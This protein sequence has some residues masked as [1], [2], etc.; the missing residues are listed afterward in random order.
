MKLINCEKCGGNDFFEQ[1]GYRICRYCRS[2]YAL[3]A[4]DIFPQGSRIS[5][6]EDIK[7]L[8]QKCQAD[9]ANARRYANLILDIDP[10]NDEAI[11]YL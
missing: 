2:K 10:G 8:L 11:K 4:D 9:P 6:G 3:H 1:N 5:L 7:M